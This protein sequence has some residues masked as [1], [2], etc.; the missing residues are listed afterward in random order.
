MLRAI[1]V[2]LSVT[3]EQIK[4]HMLPL[5]VLIALLNTWLMRHNLL[6][7]Y[8]VGADDAERALDALIHGFNSVFPKSLRGLKT[9]KIVFERCVPVWGGCTLSCRRGWL[10]WRTTQTVV[11]LWVC[12]RGS[13]AGGVTAV[14]VERP[15]V[16]PESAAEQMFTRKK[17]ARHECDDK[18]SQRTNNT[19]ENER[20]KSETDRNRRRKTNSSPL[21]TAG[22]QMNTTLTPFSNNTASFN[23]ISL[24]N[25]AVTFETWSLFSGRLTESFSDI[26]K[27]EEVS[28]EWPP[29]LWASGDDR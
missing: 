14:G 13:L 27:S 25:Q 10:S 26:H 17:T 11:W 6:Q 23:Q 20:R 19:E 22:T 24:P 15:G 8:F 28:E 5:R 16:P 29:P 18:T 1:V 4:W 12:Q 9:H 21:S 3:V 2:F 7:F